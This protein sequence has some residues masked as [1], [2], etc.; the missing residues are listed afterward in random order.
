MKSPTQE[1]SLQY[2]IHAMPARIDTFL[3]P[4]FEK[5]T[6]YSLHP[7]FQHFNKKN[8]STS[9]PT[10]RKLG[11]ESVAALISELKCKHYQKYIK[12][13]FLLNFSVL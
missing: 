9:T 12:G 4:T 2:F 3:E 6:D 13:T 10:S 11:F 5:N 7:L 1:H 8:T